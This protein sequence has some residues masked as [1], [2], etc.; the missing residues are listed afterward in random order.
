MSEGVDDRWEKDL[1]L[2]FVLV[3]SR[4]LIC[5]ISSV[6]LNPIE[7]QNVGTFVFGVYSYHVSTYWALKKDA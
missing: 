5:F 4:G 7:T 6:E 3:C 2:C 1:F